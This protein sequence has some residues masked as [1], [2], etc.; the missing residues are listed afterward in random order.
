MLGGRPIRVSEEW[1]ILL[2]HILMVSAPFL[3]LARLH[4]QTLAPWLLGVAC[5][6]FFWSMLVMDA[7]GRRGN[8][9]IGLG[10][11]MLASP[12]IIMTA[13][14]VAARWVDARRS[15]A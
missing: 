14:I 10:F 4:V 2:F 12:F 11:L 7:M 9:N 1:P 3:V 13:T 15:R 8:A 6:A 5:T